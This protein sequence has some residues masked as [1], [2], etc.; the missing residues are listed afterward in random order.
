MKVMV[1]HTYYGERGGE[2]AVYE[3]EVALM[4]SRG[5]LVREVAF[6]NK[7]FG[8]LK[9]FF[10]LWN[11]LSCFRIWKEVRSF[12]PDVVHVHNLHFAASPGVIWVLKAM[13]VPVVMTLHNFRLICPSATLFLNGVTDTRSTRVAFPWHAVRSR[14]YRGSMLLTFWVAFV[15]RFHDW[16]GTWAKVD[17][18]ILLNSN[19]A[20]LFA[21]SRLHFERDRMVIKPNFQ[22][23]SQR[24]SMV[25]GNGF[26][27]VGRLSREKGLDSLLDAFSGS[28]ERLVIAGDGE[29]RNMAMERAREHRNIDYLG[30]VGR[31][32][33][34]RRM[35]SAKG[36]VFTSRT[37]EGLPMVI[38]GAF[39]QAI[40]VIAQSNDSLTDYLSDGHNAILYSGKDGDR[41]EDAIRRFQALS[42]QQYQD[43]REAA[44]QTYLKYFTPTE[45]AR[46]LTALY[47]RLRVGWRVIEGDRSGRSP[48]RSIGSARILKAH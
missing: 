5:T 27:Y 9:F 48:D 20:N 40:P 17:A 32:E 25:T 30:F 3:G 47:R 13:G 1:V 33:V 4:R 21:G 43:M 18:F 16:I 23:A 42:P 44:Y 14:C 15:S 12:R 34:S 2:D 46:K 6:R 41:L 29:L 36:L 45:N 19:A 37:F 7:G 31:D 39:A 22:E 26:I 28:D 11:P 10:G 38:V 35:R 8:M 24:P